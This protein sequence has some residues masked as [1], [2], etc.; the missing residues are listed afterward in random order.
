MPTKKR[1]NCWNISC[2][3]Q[4]NHKLEIV[5]SFTG[6]RFFSALLFWTEA[7]LLNLF[8]PFSFVSHFGRAVCLPLNHGYS[9]QLRSCNRVLFLMLCDYFFHFFLFIYFVFLLWEITFFNIIYI[10]TTVRSFSSIY[11]IDL[12]FHSQDHWFYYFERVWIVF[13]CQH[14]TIFFFV[15]FF[16]IFDCTLFP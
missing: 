13:S 1:R 2:E 7:V 4:L 14:R 8:L 10:K 12:W 15:N 11:F 5:H 16:L 3:H 9:L 6:T